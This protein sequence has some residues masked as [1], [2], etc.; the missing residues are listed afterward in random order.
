MS[1]FWGS[2]ANSNR[3]S[4]VGNRAPG[5]GYGYGDGDGYNTTNNGRSNGGDGGFFDR[6]LERDMGSKVRS[7]RRDAVIKKS[8]DDAVRKAKLEPQYPVEVGKW[9]RDTLTT[10]VDAMQADQ[11]D[12]SR[13]DAKKRMLNK[14]LVLAL[15]A[16]ARRTKTKMGI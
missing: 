11:R 4:N 10:F 14:V 16:Y 3:N 7:V 15:R 8:V 6:D 5:Y 9:K 12:R 2:N 1:R 13:S